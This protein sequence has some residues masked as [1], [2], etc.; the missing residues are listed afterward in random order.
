MSKSRDIADSAA[1]INFIDGLTSDAQT[2]IDSKD[3]FPSQTGNNGLF[4][5]TDG[6]NASWGAVS[7]GFTMGTPVAT[8]S[9]TEIT[10]T[11]IPA[12]TKQIVFTFKNV[13]S[14]GTS[15]ITVRA[16]T[17][18]GLAN[19][20]Y[21]ATA[22]N[23]IN[24]SVATEGVTS[25]WPIKAAGAGYK[26]SGSIIITLQSAT[27]NSWSAQGMWSDIGVSNNIFTTAGGV[28]LSGTL[29][30][31]GIAFTSGSDTFDH[32]EINIAYLQEKTMRRIEINVQNGTEQVLENTPEE[33]AQWDIMQAEYAAGANDRAAAEIRT[34]RDA[35]LSESDW[36]QVADAPVDK[37][38]W[39]TYRQSLRDVP[40]QSGFPNEVTWPTEP[41]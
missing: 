11:G 21:N 9:G 7:A 17:S 3:S 5:T 14:S 38:A 37:T 4:L 30:R 34:E 41:E 35:K 15:Q 20:N 26:L 40:S 32:G 6:T 33:Q 2:Q 12:G 36:T 28:I 18:A 13:S 16:G 29:D 24:T 8:T 22:A 23:Q 31:V 39:A 27:T 10:F 19:S 1:T 25:G